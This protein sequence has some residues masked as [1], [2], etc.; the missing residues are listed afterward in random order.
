MLAGAATA[1]VGL[2]F[3]GCAAVIA[4]LAPTSRSANGISGA[5]VG[6]AF[7]LRAI[8]DAAGT[9]GADGL[10]V[11]SAW[12]SWLSPIGWGQQVHAFTQQ[13][14]APLA[15]SVAVAGVAAASATDA[16]QARRDSARRWGW[17]GGNSG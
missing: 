16:R 3:I 7:V 8:G 6:A 11:T 14:A 15:L 5:L 10:S 1:S 12:P 17:P 4:Q 9:P 13:N 2:V